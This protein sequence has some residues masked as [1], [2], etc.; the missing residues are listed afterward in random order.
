MGKSY[1]VNPSRIRRLLDRFYRL[2]L[3]DQREGEYYLHNFA[4]R[5]WIKSSDDI[6]KCSNDNLPEGVS[7]V[8]K[9]ENQHLVNTWSTNCCNDLLILGEENKR[10]M[11]KNYTEKAATDTDT[12][13]IGGLQNAFMLFNAHI[14]AIRL[15]SGS[16]HQA[17]VDSPI[18]KQSSDNVLPF[19]SSN[20]PQAASTADTRTG[21]NAPEA[22]CIAP[23]R[24]GD[25]D[26]K[27]S[28]GSRTSKARTVPQKSL[29]GRSSFDA[30]FGQTWALWQA[31]P[32]ITHHKRFIDSDR[33]AF[34][35]TWALLGG[36]AQA[37]AD[38][39]TAIKRY[40]AWSVGAKAGRYRPAYRWTFCEFIRHKRGSL[41]QRLAS[42]SWELTCEPFQ[43]A[44]R[45][46]RSVASLLAS[47]SRLA[48]EGGA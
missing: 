30:A 47:A 14:A 43:K 21:A 39:Q 19:P 5:Q 15:R 9:G 1:A 8:E 41:I 44:A 13:Y 29:P 31:L 38:I 25:G 17:F 35:R 48:S 32:G 34:K 27:G 28:R 33:Q 2:S 24:R 22:P 4:S 11:G 10:D 37:L 36:D 12:E 42:D 40:S 6:G 18:G 45:P 7:R 16:S 46:D 23:E 26:R 20:R 3:L